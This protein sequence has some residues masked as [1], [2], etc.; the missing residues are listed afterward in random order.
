MT[1]LLGV[2]NSDDVWKPVKDLVDEQAK[3]ADS[4][5]GLA[6]EI[7]ESGSVTEEKAKDIKE[8]YSTSI[9]FL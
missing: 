1:D 2:P 4:L 7:F 9:E 3:K 5:R 8:A 6:K